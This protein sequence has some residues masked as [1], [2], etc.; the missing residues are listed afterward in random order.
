MGGFG[1][2]HELSENINHESDMDYL[3]T[4]KDRIDHLESDPFRNNIQK[5]LNNLEKQADLN[6]DGVV[7]RSEMESY[8]ATQLKMREDQL[9]ELNRK[10]SELQ[11]KYDELFSRH[12]NILD[13]IRQ[14]RGLTIPVSNISNKAIEKFVSKL[15]SD[16]DINIYGLPDAVE[17]AV[18]KNSIRLMMGAM[19][20]LFSNVQL[21]FIGHK[22]TV[23]M[24]PVEDV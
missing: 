18:Y 2:K 21:E 8:M 22:I 5:R 1:S 19:E 13:K 12:E 23:V 10:N 15:L 14:E 16:P 24:Q 6:D 3:Q 11:K 9:I 4:L 17:S 20:K 7:T